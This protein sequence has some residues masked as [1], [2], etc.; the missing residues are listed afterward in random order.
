VQPA[1]QVTAQGPV[2]GRG[3][4]VDEAVPAD[5]DQ[6]DEI[7]HGITSHGVGEVGQPGQPAGDAIG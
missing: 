6:A 4:R 7:Q 5:A 1:P 3:H 2:A